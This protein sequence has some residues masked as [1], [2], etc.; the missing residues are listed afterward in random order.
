MTSQLTPMSSQRHA[1]IRDLLVAEV[2]ASPRPSG[3]RSWQ[4][5][6]LLA[7]TSLVTAA[8]VTAVAMVVVDPTAQPTYASWTAVPDTVDL[9]ADE[10][11][12]LGDWRSRCTE[13]GTGGIGFPGIEPPRWQP[14]EVLV[15]RRGTFVFCVDIALGAPGEEHTLI[16]MAGLRAD[17]G[18]GSLNTM[19]GVVR[20]EP[21]RLPGR[22]EVVVVGSG[23]AVPQ[24][25]GVHSLS[26][27]EAFGLA[28][29]DV[30]GVDIVLVS[31]TRVTAT[32]GNGR[33]G[34]WWPGEK[35]AFEGAVLEVRTED[36]VRRVVPEDAG[37]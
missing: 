20:D 35:G 18:F 13:L 23:E 37:L 4:R 12:S 31:G 21:V 5:P 10:Q 8:A 34:A 24:E 27:G 25:E 36:G 28:G 15:D 7:A 1:A 11:E 2:H 6:T 14:R 26:V 30:T 32:V 29:P 3:H 33:W 9:S 16:G 17:E 22:D 19:T